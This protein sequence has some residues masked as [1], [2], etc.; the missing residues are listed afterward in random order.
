M[1]E[2][3][4]VAK[5]KALFLEYNWKTMKSSEQPETLERFRNIAFRLFG[6]FSTDPYMGGEFD[7]LFAAVDPNLRYS[8]QHF[9]REEDV[10]HTQEMLLNLRGFQQA[11]QN[12]LK[13]D[14]LSEDCKRL[15]EDLER[16][17]LRFAPPEIVVATVML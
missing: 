6:K 17:P 11:A 12:I 9:E 4:R 13:D 1:E 5:E 14:E 8:L 3:L 7:E 2:I 15:I 10:A 16:N